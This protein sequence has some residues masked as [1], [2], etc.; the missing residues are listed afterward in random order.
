MVQKIP[1]PWDEFL[2]LLGTLPLHAVVMLSPLAMIPTRSYSLG[3]ASKDQVFSD[4][5]NARCVEMEMRWHKEPES[6]AS[7]HPRCFFPGKL[8]VA[9]RSARAN[10]RSKMVSKHID[11]LDTVAV[12]KQ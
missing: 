6:S 12:R 1:Q 4:I 7:L 2:Y 5:T 9:F 11:V 3:L 10:Q 8:C